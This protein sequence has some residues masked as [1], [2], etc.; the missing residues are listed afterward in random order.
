M[1]YDVTYLQILKNSM[2]DASDKVKEYGDKYDACL[3]E[4]QA[5]CPHA[6]YST[7]D[8]YHRGGY[9]YLSSVTIIEK[10]TF[11]NKVLR[12]YDD[13]KHVGQHG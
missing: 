12:K 11:C 8:I 5:K 13:P 9:D 10:C 1:S 4:L 7:E 2:K 3:K 6:T